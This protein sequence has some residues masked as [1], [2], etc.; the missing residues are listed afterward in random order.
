MY[1]SSLED[2][3]E[4]GVPELMAAISPRRIRDYGFQPGTLPT[5]HRND[6][7]DVAGVMVGHRTVMDVNGG[8]LTGVTAIRPHAGNLYLER[9]PAGVYVGNGH[10]KLAG[11]T[12]VQELG[13]LESPII[14]VNT[15]STGRAIEAVVD[16]T[17]EQPGCERV[18]SVN[19]F[20]GETNDS[21]LNDIRTRGISSEDVLSAIRFASTEAV[22]QGNVGAGAGTKAFGLKGGIGSSSDRKSVV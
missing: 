9:V 7:T 5:G 11:S 20:V 1:P 13:E 10:G 18:T 8:V 4:H 3:F 12:Q 6:L 22:V 17:L 21:P 19:A 2:N 16:W 15:L 14:L